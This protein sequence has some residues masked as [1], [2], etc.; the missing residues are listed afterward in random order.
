MTTENGVGP[1]DK[2]LE[3]PICDAS[4]YGKGLR[5]IRKRRWFLW[6]VILVYMPA[7]WLILE[8]TGSLKAT[9]PAFVVWFICLCITAGISAAARCPECGNY[10]H[11]HG[12]TLLYMRRCLHCGLHL[13]ADKKK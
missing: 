11:M 9:A 8:M 2:V 10:F 13:K 1:A 5:L 7:M 6:G 4:R 12:M 3:E